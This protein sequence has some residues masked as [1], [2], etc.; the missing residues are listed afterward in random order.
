MGTQQIEKD[1]VTSLLQLDEWEDDQTAMTAA[2]TV[3]DSDTEEENDDDLKESFEE[4]NKYR[5]PPAVPMYNGQGA[6]ND[7]ENVP[8]AL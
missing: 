1:R 6:S 7:N 8:R 4:E 2:T 3:A 5:E